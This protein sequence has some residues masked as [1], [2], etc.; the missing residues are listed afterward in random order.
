M[1]TKDVDSKAEEIWVNL[2]E[3]ERAGVHFGL[4]PHD[5]VAAA[6]SEGFDSYQLSISLMRVAQ[7]KHRN[8]L[9]V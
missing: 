3:N 1:P 4:F 8:G 5:K 7:K 9:R 2:S 6:A